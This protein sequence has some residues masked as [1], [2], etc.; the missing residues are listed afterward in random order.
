MTRKLNEADRASVDL[1]FDRIL[2]AATSGS[3]NGG[4]DGSV[5]VVTEPV[6]DQRLSAVQ[7]ILG[8]LDTMPA[9][10]P[11]ADLA[12]RTLQRIARDAGHAAPLSTPQFVDPTQP[13]A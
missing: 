11:P 13:M 3:S 1:V 8:V 6:S 9:P 12:T 4:G 5:V 2:S 7:R 10:E